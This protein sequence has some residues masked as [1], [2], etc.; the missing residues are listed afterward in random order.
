MA[1]LF[2]RAAESDLLLHETTRE[3]SGSIV[4]LLSSSHTVC[5]GINPTTVRLRNAHFSTGHFVTNCINAAGVVLSLSE[6]GTAR[7]RLFSC[8]VVRQCPKI[9]LSG[10]A[11]GQFT[12][13]CRKLPA[14]RARQVRQ[15][16]QLLQRLILVRAPAP[17]P[18]ETTLTRISYQQPLL[19]LAVRERRLSSSSSSKS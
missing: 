13:L 4:L 3:S 15:Q 7:Q 9:L 17:S 1:P 10:Y 14:A 19:L 11:L 2:N 18:V 5:P 6:V 16:Q 8:K 12:A